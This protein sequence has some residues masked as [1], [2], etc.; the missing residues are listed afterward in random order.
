MSESHER[1]VEKARNGDEK[2]YGLLVMLYQVRLAAALRRYFPNDED[3]V[4]DVLQEAF[5]KAWKSL[6]TFK[7]D[8]GLFTWLYRIAINVAHDQLS[9][10]KRRSRREVDM[11]R[12]Q[13]V[14]I[15]DPSQVTLPDFSYENAHRFTA[16]IAG[17]DKMPPNIQ[18]AYCLREEGFSYSE[19]A[20]MMEC[21]LNTVRT[22]IFRA[23]TMLADHLGMEGDCGFRP[24]KRSVGQNSG[25]GDG[26]KGAT[27][28]S[29]SHE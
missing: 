2:A 23:R 28:W 27:L 29:T 16:I 8:S 24:E 13:V 10:M 11:E 15:A 1:L 4:A 19:I 6:P 12:Q 7:G 14:E 5:F 17:I 18:E 21:P 9:E 22:R 20:D 26:H 25:K 3:A